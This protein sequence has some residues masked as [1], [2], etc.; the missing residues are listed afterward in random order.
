MLH[1]ILDHCFRAIAAYWS[2]CVI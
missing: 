2:N 1:L